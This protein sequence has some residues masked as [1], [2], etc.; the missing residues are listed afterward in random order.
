MIK[1]IIFD[2][3]GTLLDTIDDLMSACNQ[4]LS[5]DN[6][7]QYNRSDYQRFVG[8]GMRV[9][10]DR[11]YQHTL[12]AVELDNKLACFKKFYHQ[13]YCEQT[14]PYLGVK[15]A[16]IELQSKGIKLAVCT[17]K[18]HQY[19]AP[20]LAKFLPEITFVGALGEQPAY[21]HKPDPT[22][23]LILAKQMEC[24]PEEILFVGDSEVDIQTAHAAKMISC[25]VTWGF[26]EAEVLK[27]EGATYLVSAPS[28]WL[29]ILELSD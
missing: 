14:Q 1:G 6:L 12:S 25:G 13:V 10:V 19:V 21:P 16:L 24:L 23:A 5:A 26:R 2:L 4:V 11:A 27:K 28:E 8:N 20:M 18:N 15:E 29:K 22:M 9:L 3:D 7:P 17:N